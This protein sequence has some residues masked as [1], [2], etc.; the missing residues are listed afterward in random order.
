[1]PHR[2]SPNEP[3]RVVV[4]AFNVSPL[5]ARYAA[6]I[7]AKTSEPPIPRRL[8]VPTVTGY[9]RLGLLPDDPNGGANTR[10]PDGDVDHAKRAD[11]CPDPGAR[12]MAPRRVFAAHGSGRGLDLRAGWHEMAGHLMG[13]KRGR[14]PRR[15]IDH[16]T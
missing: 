3:R 7:S 5:P 1:M 11:V 13:S 9:V 16:S 14:R 2:L 6:R 15:V 10:K 4:N 8:P 12:R